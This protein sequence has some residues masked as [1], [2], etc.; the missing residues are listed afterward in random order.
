MQQLFL[1]L[2]SILFT[3]SYLVYIKAIIKGQARPHRTTRLVILFLATLTAFSLYTQNSQSAFWLAAISSFFSLII[4]VLSLKY[5]M[6]GWSRTD[7]ICLIFAVIGIILWKTTNNPSLALYLAIAADFTGFFPTLV[8]TYRLPKSEYWLATGTGGLGAFF[9]LISIRIFSIQEIAYPLYL[10]VM[11]SI[12]LFLI[13]R[14][15]IRKYFS[16]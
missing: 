13:L 11:E 6:G 8:K 4:F 1:S 14:P 5:G 12:L 10:L 9:N 15:N 16:N 7:I 2:G 3:I